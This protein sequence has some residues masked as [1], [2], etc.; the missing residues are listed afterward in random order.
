MLSFW[1]DISMTEN[2]VPRLHP[3]L[4]GTDIAVISMTPVSAMLGVIVLLG[5]PRAIE[6][7][8]V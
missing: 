7:L 5:V 8:I 1:G 3:S 4:S 2:D 6:P